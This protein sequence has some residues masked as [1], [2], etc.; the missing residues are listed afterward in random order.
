MT[1]RKRNYVVGL[2]EERRP[3]HDSQKYIYP[4]TMEEAISECKKEIS[5]FPNSKWVIYKLVRV[6]T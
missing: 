6:K 2:P 3:V 4:M 1:A 5:I